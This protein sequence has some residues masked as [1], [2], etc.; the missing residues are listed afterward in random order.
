MKIRDFICSNDIVLNDYTTYPTYVRKMRITKSLN[1]Y[2]LD[3]FLKHNNYYIVGLHTTRLTDFEISQ[4]KNN[5]LNCGE[6]EFLI[7]KVQNLPNTIEQNIKVELLKFLQDKEPKAND[8]IC[9]GYGYLDLINDIR[10]TR[11]FAQHWGGET[12]YDYYTDYT[13]KNQKRLK[14][15]QEKLA[16]ISYPCIVLLRIPYHVFSESI[17]YYSL[18]SLLSKRNYKDITGSLNVKTKHLEVID[19]IKLDSEYTILR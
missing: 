14:Y 16:Q 15:I 10:R 9:C 19:I 18:F 7:T 2:N 6:K 17:N 3:E 12:I 5:G 11:I 1:E 4:I 13:R 8:C